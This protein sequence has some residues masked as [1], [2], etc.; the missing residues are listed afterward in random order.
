MSKEAAVEKNQPIRDGDHIPTGK[1]V[2][3]GIQHTFTMFGA[4][5][6]VPLITGLD[7]SVALFM[8]GLGTLFFHLVTK[9]KVPVFLG[10]SFAFIAPMLMVSEMYGMQ[11]VQ[12][13]IVAAGL[14]YVVIAGL[15]YAFGHEKIVEY[16]PPIVT[17]PIIMIIGLKLAPTAIS[18]ASENWLLALVSLVI[19]TG[20]SVYAKG[21]LQVLPVLCGLVGGYIFAVL[22]GNV[23]F[24]PIREAALFGFP[25]FTLPKFNLESIMIIAPIAAATVVE[26]IGNILV[27]GTTV[28]EDYIKSPGLHRTLIGDGIATSVSAFFGGPANTTYAENTGVLALTKIYHPVI[29]RI[30]ACFAIILGVMP[31]LGAVITTIPSAIVGGIS[32]VLFGMIASV[33]G[34]SLV[35]NQVDFTSSRNLIIAAVIFVIGLGGAILPVEIGSV[36]FT[37]E[38]M[39]LA[40]IAGIVLNKVLPK[41]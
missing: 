12:G 14:T 34:R 20:V 22:T 11:Y 27:V 33:G 18:M 9:R 25:N 17:G 15:V 2:I 16:F 4:T 8:A 23:D 10:S 19:V 32:I 26:H 24:T 36:K 40:A 31:K 37:L 38:S 13:G 41:N 21:F 29:M 39:A 3:L 6:L 1:K 7:I 30:A 5:V 28:E 35:E